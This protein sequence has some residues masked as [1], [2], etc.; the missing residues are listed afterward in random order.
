MRKYIS[1]M[2]TALL[3]MMT[4]MTHPVTHAQ[5]KGSYKSKD[6]VVYGKLS[7]DG[8]VQNMYVVNS[9]NIEK[10]GTLIDYGNYEDLRNLT[11]LE[12][13]EDRKSTR[14]NSSHVAISYAVF[15]LKKKRP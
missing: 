6:E 2:M 7:S 9:F 1:L 10:H 11:N 8:S 3:L 14:L 12:P 4:F 13:I 15:C 5:N